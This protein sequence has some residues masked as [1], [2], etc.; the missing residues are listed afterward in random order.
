MIITKIRMSSKSFFHVI[1]FTGEEEEGSGMEDEATED[2]AE[3]VTHP[4]DPMNEES[5]SCSE[6][7]MVMDST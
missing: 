5:C 6:D 4:P 1:F 3:P 2:A 7:E